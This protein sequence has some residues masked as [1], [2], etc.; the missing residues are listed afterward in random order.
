LEYKFDQETVNRI[1]LYGKLEDWVV[2]AESKLGK[3]LTAL[4]P[5]RAYVTLPTK[6]PQMLESLLLETAYVINSRLIDGTLNLKAPFDESHICWKLKVMLESHMCSSVFPAN[7]P[8]TTQFVTALTGYLDKVVT[9]SEIKEEDKAMLKKIISDYVEHLPA[10]LEGIWKNFI[11]KTNVPKIMSSVLYHWISRI[12]VSGED[13][14]AIQLVTKLSSLV[15]NEFL[16]GFSTALGEEVSKAFARAKDETIRF[17]YHHHRAINSVLKDFSFTLLYCGYLIE[18]KQVLRM[19]EVKRQNYLM[20][21]FQN[22]LSVLL[23][24]SVGLLRHRNESS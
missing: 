20:Q 19:S 14:D 21:W 11:S 5:P 18:R 6:F 2:A 7:F 17:G 16:N 12:S 23:K 9:P 4:K 13:S 8:E 22:I 1:K 10:R 24:N 15:K 3:S